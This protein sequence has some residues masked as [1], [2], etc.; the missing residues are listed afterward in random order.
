MQSSV[1]E[2]VPAATIKRWQACTPGRNGKSRPGF[3]LPHQD[4]SLRGLR[5]TRP[6]F[7]P[8]LFPRLTENPPG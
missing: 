5:R 4:G 3:Q 8:S 7:L 2:A 1:W 6:C